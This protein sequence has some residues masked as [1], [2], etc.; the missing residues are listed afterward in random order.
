LYYWYEKFRLKAY[1]F[2]TL[3]LIP[4]FICFVLSYA[5]R[6]YAL[7]I[8]FAHPNG[9]YTKTRD[10]LIIKDCG[11]LGYDSWREAN[12]ITLD[13][14]SKIIKKELVIDRDISKVE[15]INFVMSY[16]SMENIGGFIININGI[17]SPVISC[18]QFYQSGTVNRFK[19]KIASYILKKGVN[20]ITLKMVN[21]A[22]LYIPIDTFYNYGRSYFSDDNGVNWR[23]IKGEY[24]IGLEL[25]IKK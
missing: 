4:L 10:W 25:E 6:I 21:G 16:I 14:N 8:S 2:I 23:K 24:Q 17:A 9:V 11:N 18:S 7:S 1:K 5:E 15:D 22:K 20:I 19:I 12:G 13:S 3:S